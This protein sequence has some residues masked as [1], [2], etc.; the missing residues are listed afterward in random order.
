MGASFVRRLLETGCEHVD[1]WLCVDTE[2]NQPNAVGQTFCDCMCLPPMYVYLYSF[3]Q[4]IY[5]S[6]LLPCSGVQNLLALFFLTCCTSAFLS[7]C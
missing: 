7:P 4:F 5:G 6:S 1:V 2:A 3:D